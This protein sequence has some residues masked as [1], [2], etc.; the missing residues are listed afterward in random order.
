MVLKS[1][2]GDEVVF[3]NAYIKVVA[4][5]G[6]K[7]L[8]RIEVATHK[9]VDGVVVDRQQ[10]YFVPNLEGKNFIIQAYEHLKTLPEFEGAIDC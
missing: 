2:F 10:H 1:N 6:N 7:D 5:F 9:D 3:K 8:M 4:L